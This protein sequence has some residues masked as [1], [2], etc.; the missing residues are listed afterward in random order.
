[1][2]IDRFAIRAEGLFSSI[3]AKLLAIG[4]LLCFKGECGRSERGTKS[5]ELT[6]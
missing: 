6:G 2:L 1:M 5:D 3:I 4:G